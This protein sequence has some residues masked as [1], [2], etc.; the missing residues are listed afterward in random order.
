MPNIIK[1][2]T[3]IDFMAY[4][5]P[6]M[7]VS[8][9]LVILS[10][11]SL[12][13]PGPNLGIDFAGGT[14]VQLDFPAEVEA[15]ELRAAIEA[16]GYAQPDVVAVEGSTTR[17]LIRVREVSAIPEA[18]AAEIQS[19][20][21]EALGGT[22]R[23][24]DLSPGGDKITIE[25]SADREPSDLESVLRGAGADV[26][27]VNRFGSPEDLRYEA[28]L[29]GI[30]DEIVR[31]LQDALGDRG[32][33]APLS[34]EWV[35]PKAGNQLRDA[36]IQALIYAVVFIMVYVVL[37]FDLRF[38]PGGVLALTH[39]VLITL[40][41]YVLVQRE[42]NLTTI[43][44]LLTILGYS[45]NDTIVVYD[46]IRENL[47]RLK[48]A[49][50]REVINVSTSQMLG[51]T[52]VTSTTTLLSVLAFFIWGTP[53]IQDIAFALFVGILIGTISSIYVAAPTT[54]W[55]DRRFFNKQAA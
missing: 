53:V 16:L 12:F 5:K 2:G 21:E 4:R 32:P 1:P 42:L 8:L 10:L 49:S 22:V 34:I 19:A 55:M 43:A 17:Y 50:L 30:G 36:A 44:A 37:R 15:G 41:I 39:D 45:I 13:T 18:R 31:G 46:R 3:N 48:D 40:G 47:G 11:V 27:S 23:D 24:F 33:N 6:F 26:R 25:L 52:L 29:V 51:R 9:S 35:G 38:A 14:E 54:E 28:H 20:A 7:A